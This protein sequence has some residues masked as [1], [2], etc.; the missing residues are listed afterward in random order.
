ME[1]QR[2]T[3]KDGAPSDDTGFTHLCWSLY[4]AYDRVPR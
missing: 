3:L 2:V 4:V 1:S